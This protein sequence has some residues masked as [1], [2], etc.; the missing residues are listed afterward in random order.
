MSPVYI[1]M[2]GFCQ[3]GGAVGRRGV[4]VGGYGIQ[5]APRI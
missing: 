4:R 1:S 2:N 3:A 5:K